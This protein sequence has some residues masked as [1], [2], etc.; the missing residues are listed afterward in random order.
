[1]A[2]GKTLDREITS[3]YELRVIAT[4]GAKNKAKSSAID[5]TIKVD[6]VN[7]SRPRFLTYWESVTVSD[8]ISGAIFAL[9]CLVVE[10]I[11]FSDR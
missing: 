6:D 11:N 1:M 5:V 8:V 4:D 3:H 2:T 10:E 9:C 7:D